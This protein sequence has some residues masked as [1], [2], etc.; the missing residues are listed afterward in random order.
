[1]AWVLSLV[2]MVLLLIDAG[3]AAAGIGHQ[4]GWLIGSK[5]PHLDSTSHPM[6]AA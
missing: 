3:M 5:E 1:M 4:A 2:G 6:I